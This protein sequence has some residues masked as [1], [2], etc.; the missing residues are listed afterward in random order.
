MTTN[1]LITDL[2]QLNQASEQAAE[3]FLLQCCNSKRWATSLVSSRPFYDL[4]SLLKLSDLAWQHCNEADFLEAFQ[5]HPKIG[6]LNALKNKYAHQASAEQGQVRQASES[7]LKTLKQRNEEYEK[8]FGFIFIVCASGKSAE[9]MLGLL[10][11]RLK[12]NY[13]DEIATGAEEQNK[14]TRLRLTQYL[15]S[16]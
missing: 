15:T 1:K 8:K 2:Q 6:D 5:G 7:V 11:Q 3:T 14:I 16:N 12:Q 4:S 9:E 10:E 13:A